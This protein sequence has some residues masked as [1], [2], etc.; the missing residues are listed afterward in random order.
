[1]PHLPAEAPPLILTLALDP[2]S[3]A[4][5]E[6]ERQRHFP[7]ARNIVP[8]HLTLFHHLPGAEEAAVRAFLERLAGATPRF[9]LA[10]DGLRFLGRGVAYEIASPELQSLHARC[11][12]A[13]AASLIAQ[14]RQGYRPHV[15]I[16]NKADPQQAKALFEAMRSSFRPFEAEA[17]GLLLW[18]YL[19][20]PWERAAFLPFAPAVAG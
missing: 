3:H 2:V 10:I 5:F 8:A 19:G 18:R 14:D 7:P 15:T 1:M 12:E 11:A 4:L 6:A 16:Q 13:F 9:Q 17:V 20:G